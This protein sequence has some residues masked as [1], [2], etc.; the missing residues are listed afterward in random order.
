MNIMDELKTIIELLEKIR[1]QDKNYFDSCSE[2]KLLTDTEY[3]K[4]YQAFWQTDLLIG[5]VI[6]LLKAARHD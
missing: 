3:S 5:N 1:R 2:Q 4:L 6:D